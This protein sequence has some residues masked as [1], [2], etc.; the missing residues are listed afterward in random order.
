MQRQTSNRVSIPIGLIGLIGRPTPATAAP[1][2]RPRTASP[3]PRK[4]VQQ[5]SPAPSGNYAHLMPGADF[6]SLS[7]AAA[8][9]AAAAPSPYSTATAIAAAGMRRRA[10]PEAAI[11]A[12]VAERKAADPGPTAAPQAPRTLGGIQTSTGIARP[13]PAN[14]AAAAIIRAGQRRRNELA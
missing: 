2:P 9:G 4:T 8:P 11:R 13:L 7:R 12:F 3:T 6:S 5:R 14:S 1:P 10:E